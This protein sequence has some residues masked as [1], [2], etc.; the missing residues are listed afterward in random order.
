MTTTRNKYT[1]LVTFIQAHL[2][3]HNEYIVSIIT[4]DTGQEKLCFIPQAIRGNEAYAWKRQ[5]YYK[6]VGDEISARV[7]ITGT[8]INGFFITLTYA[9]DEKYPAEDIQKFRRILRENGASDLLIVMEA[10]VSGKIHYHAVA[11]FDKQHHCFIDRK[12]VLRSDHIRELCTTAWTHGHIDCRGIDRPQTASSYIMKELTK[13]SVVSTV[14]K[15]FHQDDTL[16]PR[17]I[18]CLQTLYYAIKTN[19]RLISMSRGLS[20]AVHN[21]AAEDS[22]LDTEPEDIAEIENDLICNRNNSTKKK[23]IIIT[24]AKYW[25]LF[26]KIGPVYVHTM[27][28]DTSEAQ[29]IYDLLNDT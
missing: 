1:E 27:E 20:R 12:N 4:T 7:K 2:K 22:P 15:K 16:T 11:I 29:K 25:H 23:T 14:I 10:H 26:R 17:D 24:R 8:T 28:I 19:R 3:K 9:K 18:K 21:R 6:A 5:P 13:Q